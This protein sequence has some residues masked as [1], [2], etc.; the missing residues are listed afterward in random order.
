MKGLIFTYLLTYGGAALSLYNPFVGLL[1]YVAFAILKPESL[2]FWMAGDMPSNSSRIVAIAL[3]AGWLL[4]GT[5]NW[6]LGKAWKVVVAL[7]G[8]T[9][10]CVLSTMHAYNEEFGW[11]Y[12]EELL[13]IV[14]P[15]LV[16]IT[17]IDS[18]RKLRQLVWVIIL[19]QGYVALELNLSYVLD[20]FNRVAEVGFGGMDNNSVGVAMNTGIGL[21]G[22]MALSASR[23][24]MKGLAIAAAGSMAHVVLLSFSRGGMLGLVTTG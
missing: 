12:V 8:Y 22:F 17:T 5:G 16:G 13:K 19:S 7:A 4:R 21:A 10:W 14:L 2:W 11:G 9:I 3:L 1:V 23:W 20:R 15:F 6:R 24:W 18:P